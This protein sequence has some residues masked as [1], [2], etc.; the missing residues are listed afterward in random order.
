VTVRY[1][2]DEITL[3][4]V[5]DGAGPA[6]GQNNG[7]GLVGMRERVNLFGGH[8]ETGPRDRGGWS[9]ITRLPVNGS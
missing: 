9:L 2:H 5:D 3:Q 4:V 7:H 1:N 6:S 8:L